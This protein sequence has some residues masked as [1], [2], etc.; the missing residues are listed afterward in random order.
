MSL[1]NNA[2]SILCRRVPALR[3]AQILKRCV[4]IGHKIGQ[5]T[6]HWLGYGRAIRVTSI[7]VDLER[8]TR[9]LELLGYA[10]VHVFASFVCRAIGFSERN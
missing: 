5:V 9:Q 4:N 7:V 2:I 6:T 1:N 3:G 8:L 10:A